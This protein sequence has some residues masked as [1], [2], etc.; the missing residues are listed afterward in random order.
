MWLNEPDFALMSPPNELIK[1][2]KEDGRQ[3]EEGRK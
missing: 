1:D 3:K 2:L